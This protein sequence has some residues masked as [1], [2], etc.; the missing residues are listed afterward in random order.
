[1]TRRHLAMLAF[2]LGCAVKGTV[3]LVWYL[4]GSQVAYDWAANR[5]PLVMWSAMEL[6]GVLCSP[7]GVAP[8]SC[9]AVVGETWNIL[10]FGLECTLVTLIVSYAVHAWRARRTRS[11]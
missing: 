3:Q 9:A 8:S 7:S 10:G 11:E 1:M 5:D 4:T 6:P 2:L